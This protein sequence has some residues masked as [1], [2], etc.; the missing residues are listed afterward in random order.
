MTV[1]LASDHVEPAA[2]DQLAFV[3]VQPDHAIIGARL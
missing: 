1:R 3:L 2:H